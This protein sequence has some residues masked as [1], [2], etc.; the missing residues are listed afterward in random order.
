MIDLPYPGILQGTEEEKNNQ[1]YNYLIQLREAIEDALNNIERE[2]LSV[3]FDK[4]IQTIQELIKAASDD[5][6]TAIIKAGNIPLKVSQLEND[7]GYI[8]EEEDPTVPSWAKEENPP[9]YDDTEVKARLEAL[10]QVVFP[11]TP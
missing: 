10:E 7:A 2:N 11:Q 6:K 1:I 4:Q 5:S 8:S 9:T 3:S